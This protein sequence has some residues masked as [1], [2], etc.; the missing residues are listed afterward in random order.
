MIRRKKNIPAAVNVGAW[1]EPYA[2]VITLLLSFFVL[3]YALSSMDKAQSGLLSGALRGNSSGEFIVYAQARPQS[4][5]AAEQSQQGVVRGLSEVY[6][7]MHRYIDSSG[8]GAMME[9]SMG[10]DYLFLRLDQEML[11]EAE[12]A[13]PADPENTQVLDY[14]GYG[15]RSVE[16]SIGTVCVIGYAAHGEGG[17][18]DFYLS[19]DRVR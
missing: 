6:E 8:A 11:F 5:T 17:A 4:P 19:A 12:T 15:I 14:L 9:V 2:N 18:S 7:F 1:M 16:Q 3:M 13:S 10:A